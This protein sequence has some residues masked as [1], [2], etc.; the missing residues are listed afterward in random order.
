MSRGSYRRERTT[1]R[2]ESG[3]FLQLPHA[4]LS[5]VAFLG[6][7]AQAVKLLLDIAIQY[8]GNNNGDLGASWTVM[9]KRGWKS[10]DTL[11]KALCALLQGGLIEKTRQGGRHK[12]SLYALTWKAIDECKGKLDVGATKVAS[13]AWRGLPNDSPKNKSLARPACQGDTPSGP[14]DPSGPKIDTPSVS[15]EQFSEAA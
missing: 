7:S 14:M 15:V 2:K 3:S 6:L 11:D 13:G 12:C 4:V 5:S 10:R 9:R 8:R 1:G